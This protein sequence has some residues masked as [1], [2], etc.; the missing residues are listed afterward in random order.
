LSP[1]NA[2]RRK[3]SK[4]HLNNCRRDRTQDAFEYGKRKPCS[5]REYGGG[6]PEKKRNKLYT[7]EILDEEFDPG[8][9]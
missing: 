8:S 5:P 9:G 4:A 7:V 2:G 1:A 6:W 3:I